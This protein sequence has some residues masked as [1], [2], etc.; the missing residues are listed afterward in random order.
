MVPLLSVRLVTYNHEKFIAQA[1]ESALGQKTNFPFELVIGEDCSTDNTGL[2]AAEYAKKHPDI[3]RLFSRG[4]NMGIPRNGIETLKSCSGKYIA[5]LDGDDYWTDIYK[6]QKQV[7]FLESHPDFAICF[8][9]AEIRH[10][11]DE[12][13]SNLYCKVDQETVTTRMDLALRNYIPTSSIVFRNYP[14]TEIP[15]WVYQLP[16]GDWALNLI[17]AQRG[18]IYY[19]PKLMVVYRKLVNSAW[20][21]ADPLKGITLSM[22]VLDA[23]I[24]HFKEDKDFSKQLIKSKKNKQRE[25]QE[26][27]KRPGRANSIK[28]KA[29]K[30]MINWLKKL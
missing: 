28:M 8:H 4:K 20:N 12:T 22:K 5:L 26:I 1:I 18:N 16:F 27:M 23:L 2:I 14:D 15:H 7:D 6:L 29:V 24:E 3:I 25:L 10:E 30:K 11:G 9:N 17:I 21:P 13:P 19:I